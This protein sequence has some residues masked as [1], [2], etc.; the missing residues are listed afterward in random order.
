MIRSKATDAGQMQEELKR[1]IP[2]LK[3]TV[4]ANLKDWRMRIEQMAKNEKELLEHYAELKPFLTRTSEEI[5][6]TMERITSREHH[7]NVCPK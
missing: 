6:Q 2:Q 1:V 3:V 5:E 4:R 7:L